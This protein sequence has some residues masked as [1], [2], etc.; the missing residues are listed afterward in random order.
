MN[1]LVRLLAV[2]GGLPRLTAVADG[3]RDAYG[4]VTRVEEVRLDLERSFDRP[5]GQHHSSALLAQLLP[6]G[7]APPPVSGEKRVAVVEVDL[8][9]PV[10]TYVFGEA[11]LNGCAAIVSTHR[12]SEAFYGLPPDEAKLRDRLLKEIVHELGHTLG[13]VHCRQFECVMRSST[14]VAEIDLKRAQ[15]CAECR[16]QLG[17]EADNCQSRPTSPPGG[18]GISPGAR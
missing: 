6:P 15:L 9:I 16:G 2:G 18:I 14:D 5:R 3:V 8:F 13:L 17:V 11:Q 10:L 7:G 12:L 1:G 4:L